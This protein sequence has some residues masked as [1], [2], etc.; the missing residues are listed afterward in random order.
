MNLSEELEN[1]SEKPGAYR[2]LNEQQHAHEREQQPRVSYRQAL[3]PPQG[4]AGRQSGLKRP[5]PKG[6]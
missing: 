2:Y 1:G 4:D 5:E 3:G 6:S